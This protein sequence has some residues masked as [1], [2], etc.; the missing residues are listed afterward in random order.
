MAAVVLGGVW[1]YY[2]LLWRF[3]AGNFRLRENLLST[4]TSHGVPGKPGCRRRRGGAAGE[5]SPSGGRLD[6]AAALRGGPPA[7]ARGGAGLG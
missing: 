1:Q 7:V 4:G 2:N 6:C 5:K 3:L